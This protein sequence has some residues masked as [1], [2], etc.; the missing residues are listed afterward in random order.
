VGSNPT[1]SIA[2]RA[3]IKLKEVKKMGFKVEVSCYKCNE[4]FTVEMKSVPMQDEA[5]EH[6]KA[7]CPKCTADCGE[8]VV[9]LVI[10]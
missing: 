9:S 2:P 10:K 5:Q 6:Q 3:K 1:L 4:D 7:V 8:I